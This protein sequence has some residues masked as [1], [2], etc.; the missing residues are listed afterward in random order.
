MLIRL[1][2]SASETK[3]RKHL[4]VPGQ[5]HL[6]QVLLR[7]LC[8]Y[9]LNMLLPQQP[10]VL[11]KMFMSQNKQR[12][13]FQAKNYLTPILEVI[14]SRPWH[15]L[16]KRQKYFRNQKLSVERLKP[17][18]PKRSC[19]SQ[20]LFTDIGDN[21]L[22]PLPPGTGSHATQVNLKSSMQKVS[23]DPAASTPP[24]KTAIVDIH[25]PVYAVMGTEARNLCMLCEQSSN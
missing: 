14:H 12:S 8:C 25:H 10:K 7:G 4:Y 3:V 11:G 16:N 13:L 23:P 21:F 17:Y 19:Y 6:I 9:K 5:R 18:L 15:N 24:T 2:I 20:M 1:K 22:S